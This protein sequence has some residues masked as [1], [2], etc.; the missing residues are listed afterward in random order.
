MKTYNCEYCGKKCQKV[1]SDAQGEHL[2]CNRDCYTKWRTGRKREGFVQPPHSQKWKD[3]HNERMSGNQ[4]FKGKT[5]TQESR[6]KMSAS[7]LKNLAENPETH[8]RL[9]ECT[10]G[11]KNPNWKG[12]TSMRAFE[13]AFCLTIPE[14]DAIAKQ[15]RERDGF[16]CQFCGKSRSTIVHHIIP[17]RMGIDNSMDNLLTLCSSCHFKVERKTSSYIENGIDPISI[18]YEIWQK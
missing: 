17:R 2:F 11:A 10:K 16:I 1:D 15:V 4:Y 18:F 14:W 8:K 6:N 7:V 5:H 13:E 12:G 3:V 9:S